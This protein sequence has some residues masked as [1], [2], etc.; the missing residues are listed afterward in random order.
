MVNIVLSIVSSLALAFILL[1]CTTTRKSL[2]WLYLPSVCTLILCLV[3]LDSFTAST[4]ALSIVLLYRVILYNLQKHRVFY[5]STKQLHVD[6]PNIAR[7]IVSVRQ[8]FPEIRSLVPYSFIYSER[9][10]IVGLEARS[11]VSF[12]RC[13]SLTIYISADELSRQ[14]VYESVL[15]RLEQSYM[16]HK[17]SVHKKQEELKNSKK[18]KKFRRNFNKS[19]DFSTKSVYNNVVGRQY[20]YPSNLIKSLDVNIG[21]TKDEKPAHHYRSYYRI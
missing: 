21:G 19:I 5:T 17:E 4:C 9:G 7:A 6:D 1:S 18:I 13:F 20:Q 14:G 11:M 16:K 3:V 10:V 15:Y 12:D 8:K 2:K